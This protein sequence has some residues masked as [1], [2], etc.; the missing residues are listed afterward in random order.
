MGVGF[1]AEGAVRHQTKA[2]A[3]PLP[4][5]VAGRV[6][7]TFNGNGQYRLPNP[8]GGE[9]ASYTRASTV[10]KTLEDTFM[11]DSWAKRMMILGILDDEQVLPLIRHN[12]EKAMDTRGWE[13][14]D[15]ENMLLARE[16]RTPLNRAAEDAQFASGAS[17]AAEFGTAVH[18]WCEFVDHGGSLWEVPEMFRAHV[19]QYLQ[20]VAKAGL[21]ATPEWTER[22]V[23]NAKFGI[24]GTLDRL[25]WD[26]TGKLFLGDIKT[27]KGMDFS[28]LYF[29]IQLA[30]Y[31]SADYVLSLD[32]T[33]WEP[34]PA[35][36]PDT[37]LI[38]LVPSNDAE[39]ARIVPMNMRFGA[40][41]LDT[42]MAVRAYRSQAE[43]RAQSVFYGLDSESTPER[44]AITARF[45]A[46]TAQSEAQL[47]RVWEEYQD[48]WTDELTNIGRNS[49]RSAPA[50]T[51]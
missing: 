24:A 33:M 48:V 6:E 8:Q 47:A 45:H 25:F 1:S 43:Q 35:L 30:I 4:P 34:M 16:L 13:W 17:R 18:A 21:R 9:L 50:P 46:Q 32:G 49:L 20:T 26:H 40:G 12:I 14:G 27:S 51:A 41:A 42:A 38:A 37:A 5:P 22:I 44:R 10:A 11:L 15:Q 2:H 3:L 23:L 36:D 31:H 28:W 39:A 7:P 29:A 19:F